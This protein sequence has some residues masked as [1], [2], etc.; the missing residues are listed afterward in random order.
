MIKEDGG[1]KE[2]L[3]MG[4]MFV[5]GLFIFSRLH[6]ELRGWR[7]AGSWQLIITDTHCPICTAY[8]GEV[9]WGFTQTGSLGYN[10]IPL[11]LAVKLY[12]LLIDKIRGWGSIHPL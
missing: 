7:G 4:L 8:A 11:D 12:L 1:R 9:T 10:N 6:F 2:F 3:Q 5:H